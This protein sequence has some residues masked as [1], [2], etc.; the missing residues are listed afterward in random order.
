MWWPDKG[1]Y[2]RFLLHGS[3]A[4]LLLPLGRVG[5]YPPGWRTAGVL[6]S[7]DYF[8]DFGELAWAEPG[9]R[10]VGELF[11]DFFGGQIA[12]RVKEA[13]VVEDVDKVIGHL[14][15]G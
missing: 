4:A 9:S 15:L 12:V 13:L 10:S 7:A 6:V 5:L 14:W 1:R 8:S 3:D 11:E 2:C